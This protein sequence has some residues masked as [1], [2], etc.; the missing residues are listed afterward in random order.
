MVTQVHTSPHT[1]AKKMKL[2]E[3]MVPDTLELVVSFLKDA[4]DRQNAELSCLD[5]RE[6]CLEVERRELRTIWHRL[7]QLSSLPLNEE[8]VSLGAMQAFELESGFTLDFYMREFLSI[9]NGRMDWNDSWFHP[10]NI[11]QPIDEWKKEINQLYFK[12]LSQIRNALQLSSSVEIQDHLVCLGSI[13]Q[14]KIVWNTDNMEYNPFQGRNIQKLYADKHFNLYRLTYSCLQVYEFKK[15]GNLKT[16]MKSI[17]LEPVQFKINPKR[18]PLRF[19]SFEKRNSRQFVIPLLERNGAQLKYVSR[20]LREQEDVVLVATKNYADAIQ[21]ASYSF[22]NDKKRMMAC[23]EKEPLLIRFASKEL[24]S[25]ESLAQ[26]AFSCI[27]KR[28]EIS[29]ITLFQYLVESFGAHKNMVATAVSHSYS[30]YHLA[31]PE[32]QQDRD[33]VLEAATKGLR[34]RE[35]YHGLYRDDKEIVLKCMKNDESDFHLIADRL[36]TDKNLIMDV[37]S[38]RFSVERVVNCL[39]ST[40]LEDKDFLLKIFT[41][42]QYLNN[43]DFV[44]KQLLSDKDVALKILPFTSSQIEVPI[45]P[46]LFED[47]E[48]IMEVLNTWQ[49]RFHLIPSCFQEDEELILYAL[50]KSPSSIVKV[51][52]KLLSKRNFIIKA[53][54]VGCH[55]STIPNKYLDD[56]ELILDVIT[57]SKRD[58][59]YI[60]DPPLKYVSR[61]LRADKDVVQASLERLGSSFQFIAEEFKEKKSMI[62][63]ALRHCQDTYNPAF[64]FIPDN[65]KHDRKY[66][67]EAVSQN[68][69]AYQHVPP[70]LEQDPEIV[71]TALHAVY[72]SNMVSSHIPKSVLEE[73]KTIALHLVSVHFTSLMNMPTKWKQ[74]KDIV[75]AAIAVKSR[76]FEHVHNSLRDDP[77]VVALYEKVKKEEKQN[78]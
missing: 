28:E 16:W 31:S 46:K 62:L 50:S 58:R 53:V 73:N 66:I 55:L 64:R 35:I 78:P 21:Y 20:E 25:D 39:P 24:R 4:K 75:M 41:K 76:N 8:P 13:D 74:D 65:V 17:N 69:S 48:I 6:A 22:L 72:N 59:H 47:K 5:L 51:S 12:D 61:R 23:I 67:L 34:L 54:K 1:S 60:P 77:E 19:A 43:F 56:K 40:M 45:D 18:D 2:G 29:G 38:I 36:K 57:T 37:L 49:N 32:L 15:I 63:F 26:F 27:K 71:M 7:N 9:T 68:G 14:R 3:L 10:S 52:P 70:E 42:T 33:I 30:S 11:I 44:P